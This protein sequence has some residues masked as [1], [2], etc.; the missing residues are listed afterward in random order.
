MH[1]EGLDKLIKFS[2]IIGSQTHDLPA[3][4]LVPHHYG[5]AFIKRAISKTLCI[6]V[7]RIPN[8]GQSPE[9]Q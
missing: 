1:P 4:S 9:T 3:S 2:Y 8:K 5:T 7:F 6:V